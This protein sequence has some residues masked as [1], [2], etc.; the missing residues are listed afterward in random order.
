MKDEKKLEKY[1]QDALKANA[2]SIQHRD[3]SIGSIFTS[4]E[5]G[6]PG[7]VHWKRAFVRHIYPFALLLIDVF[8]IAALFSIVVALRYDVNIMQAVSRRVLL[9][10]LSGNILGIALIGGYSYQTNANTL[11]FVSEHIIVSVGVFVGVFFVIYSFVSY[12]VTMSSA[13]SV[14]ALTLVIFPVFSIAYRYCI[15]WIKMSYQRGNALCVIGVGD[16]AIDLVKRLKDRKSTHKIAVID[17]D[18]KRVGETLIENDPTSPLIQ[19]LENLAL[20]SSMGGRY[21]ENYVVTSSLDELDEGLVKRLAVAQFSGNNVCSYEAYLMEKMQI[22]PPSSITMSWALERGF[23]LSRNVTYDRIKRFGDILFGLSGLVFLSPVFLVI[24]I[25][26]KLTSRGPVIFKQIRVGK[27]EQHFTLLKFR[28]MKVG[29]EKGAKY[30]AKN[31]SRLTLV[32]KFLRKTRLDELPQFWNVLV[33]DLSLIGPRAEWDE[34]VLG[35]EKKFPYYHFR[36][37]VKPGI[38]GW[39][40][41]NYSYGASDED[42]IEKLNYDLYYVRNHSF[43][44]DAVIIVKTIY[45][46]L[47]GRGQ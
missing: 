39:A 28:T 25:A 23:L 47:F 44:L 33:G 40:Q 29:S 14:V 3:H 21:V 32:G 22:I 26:V 38:T 43:Y 24:A 31:D 16:E 20:N 11:R 35:Y 27:R 37:A 17:P 45:I 12:G 30:T 42:T 4:S 36:H 6:H 41:V 8:F 19:P 7:V 13:R 34:L 18:G 1:S 15:S 10:I 2:D 9:V 5:E 46:V